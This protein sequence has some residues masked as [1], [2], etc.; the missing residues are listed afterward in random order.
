M[1]Q[2]A[3]TGALIE[4]RSMAPLSRLLPSSFARRVAGVALGCGAIVL[5]TWI[6]VSER[7]R[8]EETDAAADAQ[9]M[10]AELALAFEQQT[11]REIQSIDQ[12]VLFVRH[13]HVE[14]GAALDL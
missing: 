9:R 4:C 8:Y 6:L 1:H 7:V 3:P 11:I 14:E 10:T 13:E 12:L 5:A 2:P